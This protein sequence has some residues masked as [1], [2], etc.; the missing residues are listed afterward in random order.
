M[1]RAGGRGGPRGNRAWGG[2][3]GRRGGVPRGRGGLEVNRVGERDERL[4]GRVAAGPADGADFAVGG[5]EG[6][7][8]RVRTGAA[9]LDVEGATI[10]ALALAGFPIQRTAEGGAQAERRAWRADRWTIQFAA[11]QSA[12]GQ[13]LVADNL[14]GHAETRATRKQEIFGIALEQLWGDTGGLAVGGGGDE[15]F[16]EGFEVP[17]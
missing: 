10:G 17:R 15:E 3:S 14:G 12:D 8:G 7:H 5:V 6:G 13:G 1:R 9:P 4:Q 2:R 16:E 11:Q